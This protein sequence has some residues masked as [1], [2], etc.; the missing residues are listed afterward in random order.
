M[1]TVSFDHIARRTPPNGVYSQTAFYFKI[2][3]LLL[4]AKIKIY[5]TYENNPTIHVRIGGDYNLQFTRI[6]N[7]TN[8]LTVF[9]KFFCI[10]DGKP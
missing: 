6:L 1:L 2:L 3:D 8:V 10:S 5:S 7:T 9:L 4:F